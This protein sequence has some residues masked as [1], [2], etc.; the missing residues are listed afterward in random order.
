MFIDF[1]LLLIKLLI[2]SLNNLFNNIF[3]RYDS[4]CVIIS[5]DSANEVS[6]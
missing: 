5:V 6:K 2:K 4:K 3:K 1:K